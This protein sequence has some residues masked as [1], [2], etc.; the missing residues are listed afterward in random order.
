[1]RRKAISADRAAWLQGM[2]D[3]FPNMENAPGVAEIK[4]VELFLKWR[5]FVPE[6]YQKSICPEPS[7]EVLH[8]IKRERYEKTKVKLK[9]AKEKKREYVAAV[10]DKLSKK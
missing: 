6:E 4:Q 10:T 1:M 7:E 9:E 8:K 2:K 3:S 5:A